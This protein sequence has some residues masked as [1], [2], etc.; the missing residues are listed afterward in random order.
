MNES[1]TENKLK[2]EADKIRV[3]DFSSRFE[4]IQQREKSQQL[5]QQE[6]VFDTVP[7][8]EKGSEFGKIRHTPNKML[9][10]SIAVALLCLLALAIVLPLTL[11]KK[12]PTGFGKGESSLYIQ[13][14]NEE[15]FYR[16]LLASDIAVPDLSECEVEAYGLIL[17]T[18]DDTVKGGYV[19]YYDERSNSSVGLEIYSSDIEVKNDYYDFDSKCETVAIRDTTV[20]YLI[21]ESDDEGAYRMQ[22]I[23]S[24]SRY[25]YKFELISDNENILSVFESLFA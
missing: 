6:S 1:D 22:A 5:L 21:L 9:I 7:A 25:N 16:E 2:E 23:A 14:S 13:V 3:E 4:K 10:I 15:E 11:S 12:P 19:D 20:R 8:L 18:E 17:L 24:N